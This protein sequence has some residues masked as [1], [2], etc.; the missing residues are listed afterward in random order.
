MPIA[1]RDGPLDQLWHELVDGQLK[2]TGG[3]GGVGR[4]GV[5]AGCKRMACNDGTKCRRW[6]IHTPSGGN[7]NKKDRNE[8]CCTIQDDTYGNE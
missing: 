8:R 1:L 4:A 6:Q 5:G 3:A 7:S 2:G